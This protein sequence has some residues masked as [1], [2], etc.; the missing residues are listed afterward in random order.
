M[1]AGC[2]M[3]LK[4]LRL[5]DRE[6]S[7]LE[8]DEVKETESRNIVNKKVNTVFKALIV[9]MAAAFLLIDPSLARF[10][11]PELVLMLISGITLIL[12]ISVALFSF[13]KPRAW[14]YRFIAAAVS[15]TVGYR[16]FRFFGGGLY[17][18]A[19]L[20]GALP[21]FL[22]GMM[23][24]QPELPWMDIMEGVYLW[25]SVVIFGA[26]LLV[27]YIYKRVKRKRLAAAK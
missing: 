22:Y 25:Y 16:F 19:D 3:T 4:D 17:S 10:I 9:G 5:Y 21:D 8:S 15:V 20:K 13:V 6:T 11:P 23:E 12:C 18:L 2:K 24:E 1:G 14:L 26:A 7:D 27:Q